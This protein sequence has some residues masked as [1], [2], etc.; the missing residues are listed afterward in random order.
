VIDHEAWFPLIAFALDFANQFARKWGKK[1]LRPT[2]KVQ[3]SRWSRSGRA[4][5]NSRYGKVLLRMNPKL[6]NGVEQY[7]KFK[8]MPTMYLTG[9]EERMIHLAAHELRHLLGA[10]GTRD[11]E[12]ACER[13]GFAAVVAWREREYESPACLI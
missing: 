2:F 7:P 12:V 5:I 1:P 10:D 8:E 6:S 11:G 13:F 9:Y 3:R 4:P